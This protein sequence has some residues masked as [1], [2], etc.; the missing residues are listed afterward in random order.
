MS[1]SPDSPQVDPL[2][3]DELVRSRPAVKQGRKTEG[4]RNKCEGTAPWLS[5]FPW[6]SDSRG[7]GTREKKRAVMAVWKVMPRQSHGGKYTRIGSTMSPGL[8]YPSLE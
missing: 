5:T 7:H 1:I 2:V 8:Q 6:R 3:P 4:R